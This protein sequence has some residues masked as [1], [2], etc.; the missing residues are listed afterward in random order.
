MPRRLAGV[1]TQ[2]ARRTA[3]VHQ[4]ATRVG[5][6]TILAEIHHRQQHVQRV[7]DRL[8]VG[9]VHLGWPTLLPTVWCRVRFPLVGSPDSSVE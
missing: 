8:E 9:S 1:S 5:S 3:A 7:Q 4:R 6:R 2:I